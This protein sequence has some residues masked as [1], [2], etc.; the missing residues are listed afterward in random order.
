MP[1][2]HP[3][4]QSPSPAACVQAP[5]PGHFNKARPELS[6]LHDELHQGLVALLLVVQS[7]NGRG[8]KHHLPEE[9]HRGCA[10]QDTVEEL[11]VEADRVPLDEFPLHSELRI[12]VPANAVWHGTKFLL[13][14]LVPDAFEVL[15]VEATDRVL[16]EDAGVLAGGEVLLL[17][18]VR[19]QIQIPCLH[20]KAPP[21]VWQSH[22]HVKLCMLCAAVPLHEEDHLWQFVILLDDVGKVGRGLIALVGDCL[23]DDGI[24]A[25]VVL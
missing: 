5:S 21:D 17:H 4:P 20:V 6:A 8:Y 19:V 25:L 23:E 10:I 16:N 9:L 15:Y 14:E 3:H 11:L 18:V 7:C 12:A 13:E 1:V 22:A 24:L 2:V